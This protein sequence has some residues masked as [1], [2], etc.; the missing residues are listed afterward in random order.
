MPID[1]AE[2][3]YHILQV[4]PQAHETVIRAAYRALARL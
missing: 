3:A 2:N 1:P 4:H